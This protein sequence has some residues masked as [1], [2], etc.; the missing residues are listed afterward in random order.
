M[1]SQEAAYAAHTE[2]AVGFKY[3][4]DEITQD[5]DRSRDV[6]ALERWT[7]L[8]LSGRASRVTHLRASVALALLRNDLKVSSIAIHFGVSVQRVRRLVREIK[9]Q[10][11]FPGSK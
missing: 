1:T 11:G 2:P 9:S 6:Q 10:K 7:E 3:P 4:D 5:A 8:L